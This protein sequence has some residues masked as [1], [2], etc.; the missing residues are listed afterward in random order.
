MVASVQ[1]PENAN[2]ETAAD[3]LLV[4]RVAASPDQNQNS[5]VLSSAVSDFNAQLTVLHVMFPPRTAF[6][7]SSIRAQYQASQNPNHGMV[8]LLREWMSW[9]TPDDRAIEEAVARTR[10]GLLFV[11]VKS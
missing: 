8:L 2:H 3:T 11:G 5:N 4:P 10:V 9:I 7:L 1:K 6:L